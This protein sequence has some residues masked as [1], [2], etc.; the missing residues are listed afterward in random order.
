VPGDAEVALTW[1]ASPEPDVRGY[2]VY[3]GTSAGGPHGFVASTVAPSF[4]DIGLADG[5]T[6]YY[7]V[8]AVDTRFESDPSAEAAATP[9]SRQLVAEVRISPAHI[10]ADCLFRCRGD[11][12]DDVR[13]AHPDRDDDDDDDHEACP[14]QLDVAVELPAGHDPTSIDRASL[15]LAGSVAPYP[16]YYR[17]VDTDGDGLVELRVR[18]A[19]ERVAP[20]LQ[21]GTNSLTLT[22]RVAGAQFRGVATLEVAPL[23]VALRVTPRTLNRKSGGEDVLARL[24]FRQC[25]AVG[26]VTIASLRLNEAVPVKRLVTA[27]G[28][29][30]TV[31]FDRAAVIQLLPAGESIE[32]RVMGSVNGLPF[33]A[34]D[35]IRVIK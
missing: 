4:R 34:R 17:F 24:E 6:V 9:P 11:D 21:A 29:D 22:G 7:V 20:L 13:T 35:T 19:F 15:R 8:T 3:R 5:V 31:K 30:L 28:H 27:H 25:V 12:D 32:V 2:R 1:N 16:S 10:D 26:A 33:V 18:F 23:R 14:S